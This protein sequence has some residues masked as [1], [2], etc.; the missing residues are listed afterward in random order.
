MKSLFTLFA[1][2]VVKN[3]SELFDGNNSAKTGERSV[4]PKA[5]SGMNPCGATSVAEYGVC[6]HRRRK[7]FNGLGLRVLGVILEN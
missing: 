1:G 6:D 7:V 5:A 2:H 4:A 3:V